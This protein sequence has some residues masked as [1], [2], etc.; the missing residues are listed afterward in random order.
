MTAHLPVDEHATYP[1]LLAAFWEYDRALLAND[2]AALDAL[3]APGP[4][5]V[6]GDGISLAVGHDEIS[7]FR[8]AR[9]VAP[10]RTVREV[11]VV[12]AGPTQA[13]VMATVRSTA[14]SP[15]LQTQLWERADGSWRI[16]AAHVSAPVAPIDR[17]VWRVVGAPLVPAAGSGPL[18]GLTV[19]VK[20]VYA[21][22]GQRLGGGV[23]EF[24]REARP[25]PR[26]A[27]AV[28][29]LLRHGADLVGIAQTDQFA[30]SIAGANR[31][32]GIPLNPRAPHAL[33]GGSTSGGATAVALGEA[34][35]ALGTDTAGS[36]RV[37]SAY[38]GLWGLRTTFGE[39]PLD[40]VLPLAPTFDA[41]GWI[42]RDAETLRR[43]TAA[44]LPAESRAFDGAVTVGALNTL[45][46]E[47]G[48]DAA[49]SVARSLA[50]ESVDL[51]LD[52]DAAFAAFRTVQAFEAW[53]QHGEWIT[54]HPGAL[55]DDVAAR[56]A[57]AAGVRADE[58]RDAREIVRRAASVIRDVVAD[59]AL[60]LPTTASAPPA[61][62]ATAEEIDAHRA[63]TLRLCCL[64][65]I[66]GLPAV[67]FP[68]PEDP[69]VG[70]CVL[71]GRGRDLDLVDLARRAGSAP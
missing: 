9:T 39:V 17:A 67:A 23:P 71:G 18:S 63:N 54:A 28:A 57:V 53:A 21:V 34:S 14:G 62:N 52:V 4:D 20:D 58:A 10:T 2:V 45:S 51:D 19:A 25:E 6:R 35:V 61:L 29:E 41:A 40:G 31:R 12:P 55:D 5:T 27:T 32:Y 64:A 59:R 13:L 16:V 8:A 36:I 26:H 65:P 30:Y 37:P 38:Q 11:H 22:E 33:P 24:A 60:I 50:A 56:F 3:F 68:S 46:D 69:S 43:V 7:R 70:V 66:A 44:M 48:R 15:G 42:T 49:E 1:G 47:A